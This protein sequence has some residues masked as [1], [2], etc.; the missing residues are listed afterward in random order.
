MTMLDTHKEYEYTGQPLSFHRILK[1]LLPPLVKILKDL[2]IC[3][4][5]DWGTLLGAVRNGK[6]IPW[7]F[8][9]DLGIFNTDVEK[10]LRYKTEVNKAGY[11]FWTDDAGKCTRFFGKDG[12]DFHID[13]FSW[14]KTKEQIYTVNYYNQIHTEDELL[15]PEQIE[16]E[17]ALYPCP[18]NP[19]EM[20]A[21]FYG[22]D[23]KTQKATQGCIDFIV[24]HD[25][26]NIDVLNEAGK[27]I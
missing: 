7:D 5:L 11:D 1:E 18:K 4:W 17:G 6:I 24:E 26:N 22:S 2:D 15:N 16:F 8:D 23:W 12:L 21:R 14:T 20:R 9:I 27:Y 3:F 10:L 25:P 13:L 19:V